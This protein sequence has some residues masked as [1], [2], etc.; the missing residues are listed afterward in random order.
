M[1]PVAEYQLK[2]VSPTRQRKFCFS[3]PAAKMKVLC[4]ANRSAAPIGWVSCSGDN[5]VSMRR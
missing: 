4:V 3:L 5:V 1:R 2:G